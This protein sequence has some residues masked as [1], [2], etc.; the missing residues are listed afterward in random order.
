MVDANDLV[1]AREALGTA[2]AVDPTVL[3]AVHRGLLSVPADDPVAGT[4]VEE[5]CPLA[6]HRRTGT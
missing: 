3:V 1:R 2:R 6:R 4:A 5:A